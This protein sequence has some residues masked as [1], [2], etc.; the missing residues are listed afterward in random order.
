[1][2]AL[3]LGILAFLVFNANGRLISAA[4]TYAA[5][6]LPFSILEHQS[7]LLEP[8][9]TQVALGR[10]PPTTRG[11]DGSAFWMTRGREGQLISKYPLVVPLAVT[12]LYLPAVHFLEN[13]NA[14]PQLRDKVARVMEKLSASLIA[15]ASVAMMYLLLRR[16]TEVTTAC[17][18]S[19]AY[20][21][22]TTTW[23]ISSQALWMHGLAQL[24][25]VSTMWLITGPSSLPRV[26]L[27]GFTC[28]LIAANRPPDA[29]LAAAL[30]LYGLQWSQ[31]RW[32][33]FIGVGAIPIILTVTY[34]LGTAGH[35]AGAYALNVNPG[36]F[37]EDI[38]EGVAGLLLSPMRGLFVYSPFLLFVPI[39]IHHVIREQRYRNLTIALCV[40]I[41]VQI[42]G[43]AMV[44]WRQGISWGSRWLTDMLP[45]LMWMLPPIIASLSKVG[46]LIFLV[47]CTLSIAIQAIGAFWYT[48]VTDTAALTAN[49]EDR[50]N[51]MWNIRNAAF[52]AELDHPRVAGDL[53]VIL[54]GNI[55]QVDL[56]DKIVR[57]KAGGENMSLHLDVAGWS[58]VDHQ[59]PQDVAVLINGKE[60]GGTGHFFTRDDVVKAMGSANPA[61]WR[62]SLPIEE[63]PPGEHKL[64][65]VVRAYPGS[66]V[67]LLQ[68]RTFDISEDMASDPRERFLRHS[69]QV[70]VDRVVSNLQ[71]GDRWLTSFTDS[72]RFLNNQVELNTYLNA[73]MLDVTEPLKGSVSLTAARE[74]VRNFLKTQIEDGGLVRYHGRPDAPTIGVLGCAIT[75]DSDDT[76]LAWRLA[77]TADRSSLASALETMGRYRTP[78][79]LYRTW[80]AP[81]DQYECLDPGADPNP[82]DIGIQMHIYMLLAQE[83][84]TAA[85][86]LC[87]AMKRRIDDDR[88][89]VY[90]ARSPLLVLM[91]GAD[92]AREGC[93]LAIPA[94][95]LLTDVPGQQVWLQLIGIL[96]QLDT[97]QHP[98]TAQSIITAKALL[99]QIAANDFRLLSSAPP[100]L[101][102]NDLTGTVSRYYWSKDVG[103]ALWLRLHQQVFA[104]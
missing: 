1:M 101:Y 90:Y 92:L 57:D 59:T 102:H 100:M 6:H 86:A 103:Y 69:S 73:V 36:D 3:A 14:D 11:E 65:V 10:M 81:R 97:E 96:N 2:F 18:L 98:P 43:Y 68:Q 15:A 29:I 42:V 12:P 66:E 95:R 84:P 34:N 48:G 89:W 40:A 45:L 58:L 94:S 17:L 87:A 78:D 85:R 22:G 53:F 39:L 32:P 71:S 62:L 16:R 35:L 9:S 23:V 8:V 93:D 26:A 70:A 91:R 20:A 54:R 13:S 49:V 61:G 31:K 44:D 88:I 79:G 67:R 64:A 76:A 56:I 47:S 50:M 74:R 60:V 63:L 83:R 24:L 41:V 80:L 104:P 75:P 33:W 5:R 19:V 30:G 37:N 99:H 27:A 72:R 7:L 55:D 82:A 52:L 38:L 46:R 51:P 25:V 4:D 28:A 21:F 77:P